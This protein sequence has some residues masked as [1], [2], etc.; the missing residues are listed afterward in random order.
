MLVKPWTQV[1][2]LKKNILNKNSNKIY[3]NK[4]IKRSSLSKKE[5]NHAK[6]FHAKSKISPKSFLHK[7]MYEDI[8]ELQKKIKKT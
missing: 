5:L 7:H 3:M 1:D 4:K 8:T 2:T 6:Y